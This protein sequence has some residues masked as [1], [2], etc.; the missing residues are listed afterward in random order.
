MERKVQ[1]VLGLYMCADSLLL[2]FF[3]ATTTERRDITWGTLAF[4]YLTCGEYNTFL[5]STLALFNI[6]NH[7]HTICGMYRRE[8][9][10]PENKKKRLLVPPTPPFV[11][12]YSVPFNP[13]K[14]QHYHHPSGLKG[15]LQ[16]SHHMSQF[17]LL[18]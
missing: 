7:Q 9:Q 18:K 5:I 3:M 11:I 1:R 4:G 10:P 6:E 8:I 17:I 16:L 2:L 15:T 14:Q 12:S 13:H